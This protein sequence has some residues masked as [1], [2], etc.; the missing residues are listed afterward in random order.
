MNAWG[1]T[2]TVLFLNPSCP[3]SEGTR[4]TG[5]GMF[6]IYRTYIEGINVQIHERL[7]L[8]I[9]L[10]LRSVELF[11]PS[12]ILSLGWFD[13]WALPLNEVVRQGVILLIAHKVTPKT[14]V[15]LHKRHVLLILSG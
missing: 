4:P 13:L 2:G 9:A 7:H 3:R 1:K 11:Y 8:S 12:E 6:I 5:W 15:F 10:L 14:V